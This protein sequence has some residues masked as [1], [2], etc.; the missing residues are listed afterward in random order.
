[1]LLD[2]PFAR[3]RSAVRAAAPILLAG[4]C[5]LVP[6]AAHAEPEP[7]RMVEAAELTQAQDPAPV[8]EPAQVQEP[9]PASPS[10]WATT[11]EIYGFAPL[12]TTGTTTLRDFDVDLDLS[13]D[14]V[15]KPLTRAYYVRGSVEYNRIGLLTDLSYVQLDGA[16]AKSLGE[17]PNRQTIKG[18][19]SNIQGIYDVALRYRLGE[20]ETAI[21]KPGNVSIIPY[22]GVRFLDMRYNLG[23]QFEG[24]LLNASRSRSFGGTVAQPLVG[25]W[26][27]IFLAPRLRLFARGDLGGFGLNNSEDLSANA[28]VGLG[29][30][31]GD[32]AQVNLSWRYLH[33]GGS[34]DKTPENAYQLNMNGIEAGLKFF[35]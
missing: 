18:T 27:S 33:L 8:Q 24:P 25:T 4:L 11:V 6:P 17:D 22:A 3:N 15:L 19:L 30:A 34:N 20:R 7:V 31:L 12:R 28:Q 14:Q 32:R 2:I 21:G 5:G 16:Q 35:F 13:L 10:P 9:S 23:V 1:M 26:A 29:Y